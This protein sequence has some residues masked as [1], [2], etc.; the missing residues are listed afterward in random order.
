MRKIFTLAL[1]LIAVGASAATTWKSPND[2]K[3]YTMADLAEIDGTGVEK[4]ADNVYRTTYNVEIQENDGFELTNNVTI[5]IGNKLNIKVYGSTS[6]TPADTATVTFD[7]GC[8]PQGI[9]LAK[10]SEPT[11]V[12]HVRFEK[13]GLRSSGPNALIV[14][15]C[16]FVENA[17]EGSK[18]C[19]G[20]VSSSTGNII[21][22]CLFEDAKYAAVG[23][24][25]NIPCGT[26]IADCVM[27]NCSTEG[28]NYPYINMSVS[29]DNGPVIIRDN[30]IIGGKGLMAGA[31]SVSNMLSTHGANLSYIENNEMCDCRYGINILGFQESH[32]TGNKI[33]NCHYEATPANGGSGVTVQSSSE[34][35]VCKAYLT[36]NIIDGCLWGVTAVKEGQVNLGR[37]DVPETD[38][39]YNPGRNIFRNNGNTGVPSTDGSLPWDPT[40]PYDLYNNTVR[41]IYAQNNTWGCA[42]QTEAAIEGQIFHQTDKGDLG[43][44]IF[45]PAAEDA[46]VDIV[47]ADNAEAAEYFNLQGVKVSQPANGIFIRRQGNTVSKVIVK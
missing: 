44:V 28:R 20:F 29:G 30:K 25:S 17:G 12:S 32:I 23:S 35:Y 10:I 4:V 8:A 37:I 13:A 2:G 27:K 21:T 33:I 40:Q 39:E 41:T 7:D 47:E 31:I 46:G 15:N 34:N 42:E 5:K 18:N 22:N 26:T 45:L 38:P 6:M 16:T 3:I 24:G 1:S 11:T 36:D 9:W 43:Q 14:E 19:I